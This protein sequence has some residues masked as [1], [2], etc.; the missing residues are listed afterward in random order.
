M[1]STVSLDAQQLIHTAPVNR[2]QGCLADTDRSAQVHK[3]VCHE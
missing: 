1:Q 3:G 2:Y